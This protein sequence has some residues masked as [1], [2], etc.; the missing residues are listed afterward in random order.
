MIDTWDD[1]ADVPDGVV[2][3]GDKWR[4]DD[5]GLE[6][7]P[8]GADRWYLWADDLTPHPGSDFAPYTAVEVPT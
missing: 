1:L 2:V 4:H 3:D 7:R 8:E 5:D 6:W